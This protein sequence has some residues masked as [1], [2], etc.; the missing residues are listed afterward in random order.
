MD[1]NNL[2]MKNHPPSPAQYGYNKC[3]T[4]ARVLSQTLTHV[5]NKNEIRH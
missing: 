5:N 3:G 1:L 2:K 4:H